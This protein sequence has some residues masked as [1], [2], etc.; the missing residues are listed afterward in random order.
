MTNYLAIG[1]AMFGVITVPIVL[2]L[3]VMF[4]LKIF[5]ANLVRFY[6]NRVEKEGN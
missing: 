3:I 6:L 1:P 5:G 2:P 4:A